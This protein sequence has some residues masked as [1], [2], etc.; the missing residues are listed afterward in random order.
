MIKTYTGQVVGIQLHRDGAFAF[1]IGS[2]ATGTDL[3]YV[4]FKVDADQ[5]K[6]GKYYASILASKL[7]SGVF[8]EVINQSGAVNPKVEDLAFGAGG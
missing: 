3:P 2:G 1:Q 7:M 8:V 4:K 6:H 5:D